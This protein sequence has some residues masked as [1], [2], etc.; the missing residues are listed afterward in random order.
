MAS[1]RAW[2]SASQL[3]ECRWQP[4]RRSWLGTVFVRMPVVQG[5]VE[6]HWPGSPMGCEW[7]AHVAGQCG[8]GGAHAT[9]HAWTGRWR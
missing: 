5:V 3:G 1:G 9:R 7:V 4:C 6:V 2:Q 8:S